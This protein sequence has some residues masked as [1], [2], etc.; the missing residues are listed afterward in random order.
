MREETG[1]DGRVQVVEMR[2]S[3]NA[4][5]DTQ[6]LRVMRDSLRTEPPVVRFVPQ[7]KRNL[8]FFH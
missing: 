6:V 1:R 3:G 2:S 4:S 5:D 8:G 7:A